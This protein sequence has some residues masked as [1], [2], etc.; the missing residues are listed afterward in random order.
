MVTRTRTRRGV[1]RPT[2]TGTPVAAASTPVVVQAPAVVVPPT[3][4]EPAE[5]SRPKVVT[6]TRGRAA[7]RP[8]GAPEAVA[9]DADPDAG[10]A[11][12]VV[13]AEVSGDEQTGDE[14]S[15][16]HV[17]VKKKGTRKR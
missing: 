1:S 6:R 11:G 8:A 3:V 14:S 5:E 17:P 2:T 7:T 13:E 9:P 15:A 16:Q 10:A 4:V 12:A